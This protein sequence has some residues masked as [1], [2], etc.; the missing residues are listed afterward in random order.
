[1][2]Q[3]CP[4]VLNWNIVVAPGKLAETERY[5]APAADAH[6]A[7]LSSEAATAAGGTTRPGV[8][9]GNP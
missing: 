7:A 8:C 4:T 1:M 3:R 5:G 2:A 6:A 9:V